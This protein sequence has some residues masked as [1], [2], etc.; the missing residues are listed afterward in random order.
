MRSIRI[1]TRPSGGLGGSVICRCPKC[2]YTEPH[3]RGVPCTSR[4]CPRCG[5]GMRGER[6]G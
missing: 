5:A 2:G 3:K 6:C 1:G 4:S